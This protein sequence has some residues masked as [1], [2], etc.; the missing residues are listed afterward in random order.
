MQELE[1]IYSLIKDLEENS[2]PE[3]IWEIAKTFNIFKTKV[4]NIVLAGNSQDDL[5]ELLVSIKWIYQAII[6]NYISWILEE[7]KP[8]ID[9]A[10]NW[11]DLILNG[12]GSDFS[13]SIAPS[14]VFNLP[15]F[16][17]PIEIWE[18]IKQEES[19]KTWNEEF[20]EIISESIKDEFIQF[21]E[22]QKDLYLKQIDEWYNII[23]SNWV[24]KL[25][26]WLMSVWVISQEY[27][28][29]IIKAI[30]DKQL[31]N[32]FPKLKEKIDEVLKDLD[33][34]IKNN[35]ILW[36]S[37]IITKDSIKKEIQSI[38]N[39]IEAW[40][41][42]ETKLREITDNFWEILNEKIRIFE[43]KY[44]ETKIS[45]DIEDFT[46]KSEFDEY[47]KNME[48]SVWRILLK[49][50]ENKIFEKYENLKREI[51]LKNLWK[52]EFIKK[53]W[54]LIH[55]WDV[56][57]PIYQRKTKKQNWKLDPKISGNNVIINFKENSANLKIAPSD[58]KR[59]RFDEKRYEFTRE[60]YKELMRD[61]EELKK[62]SWDIKAQMPHFLKVLERLNKMTHKSYG[63]IPE[64]SSKIKITPY[65]L[66]NLKWF[67]NLATD[68]IIRQDGIWIL[69]WEAWVGKN[70]LIDI[71]ANYTN[72]P[73]FTFP[74]NKRAS[75]EDLTYA[76]LINEN[77]TYKLHSKVYE[78]IKTP[79]AILIFDE[80]NTLPTE[81]IKLL[82]GL[83][84][85]R[86]TLTMPYDNEHQKALDDV[87]IFGTQNPEHYDWT[88]KLPQDASS[89]ANK[90]YIDYP[91][92]E[93]M[94]EWFPFVN[95][96]EAII[97]YSNMPYFYKLLEVKWYSKEDIEKINLLKLRK[98]SKQILNENEEKLVQDFESSLVSEHEFIDSW[99]NIFNF[100]KID[101]VK[102]N[103]WEPFVEWL[104]DIH[105]LIKY[106][107]YIRKR[108][109]DKKEWINKLDP[110]DVSVSQRDLNKMMWLL[111]TWLSPK[112]AFIQVY[113]TS[114]SDMWN[115]AKIKA[116]LE[117]LVF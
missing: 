116:D 14:Q 11:I 67:I 73:V 16:K 117:N 32:L 64:L 60:E 18:I 71:F 61:Y 25:L 8:K 1:D 30:F 77:W 42:M 51:L 43:E 90:L 115:R 44:F 75:K 54:D 89:R 57:F 111:S 15:E 82:N 80:I 46:S 113:V 22:N 68:Q 47:E 10:K 35:D 74:C 3:K 66:K 95:Y 5:Q 41:D 86:R 21:F 85:Y 9:E 102:Q 2:S 62:S 83:F 19:E 108:Y 55:F 70:V 100:W 28:N 112:D 79:G 72:R 29:D 27:F 109:K 31:E 6:V 94:R 7:L 58:E 104:K 34:K 97:S 99:N 88:Q 53:K 101:E 33:E 98:N 107:Y 93:S 37:D 48:F 96:D 36:A 110:I 81:I 92:L 103:Y 23:D 114:I 105:T 87:L 50:N 38:I 78:A 20:D 91:S 63:D 26:E 4:D 13:I 69:E 65:I 45:F 39:Q 56:V 17:I 76:W 49:N 24:K 106:A 12:K 84:D 40:S 59:L 52:S